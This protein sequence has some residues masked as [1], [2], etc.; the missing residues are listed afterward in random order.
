MVVVGEHVTAV[1]DVMESEAF[2]LFSKVAKQLE[3]CGEG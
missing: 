2:C 3:S 1:D